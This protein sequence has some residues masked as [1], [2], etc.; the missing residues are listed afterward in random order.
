MASAACEE[1]DIERGVVIAL[2]D[3]PI[4]NL[5][6]FRG[7]HPL[8]APDAA[9]QGAAVL[10]IARRLTEC[11]L[12]IVLI[13]GGGSAMLELPVS[14]VSMADIR[15][16]TRLLLLAGADIA[17]L[18]AV[19]G[20]LSQVKGGGLARALHPARIIIIV[21]SD[22]PGRDPSLVAA[23]P[24]SRPEGWP[25]PQ[26]VIARYGLSAKLPARVRRRIA[27][28]APHSAAPGDEPRVH[29]IIAADAHMALE[30]VRA[31]AARHGLRLEIAPNV[32][33]G[34]A[35]IEGPRFVREARAR[36][37]ERLID[38]WI[39]ASETTVVVGGNGRGGRNSEAV[40]AVAN[41]KT[42]IFGTFVAIA[43]DGVDGSNDAAA[44]WLD[45]TVR[46]RG[47]SLGLDPKDLLARNDSQAFFAS[48]GARWIVG[49]T[50][51]NVA[52]IWVWIASPPSRRI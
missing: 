32:I 7:A 27:T 36:S 21:I 47:R 26:E 9:R 1:L 40:L 50:G 45:E 52:D 28:F 44:V 14:G 19:R 33:H 34:V 38:G 42:P 15:D 10:E 13:S 16:T 31:L 12:A 39:A 29:W 49:P 5:D 18:N 25:N 8:P 2:D 30:G 17:E 46:A 41:R 11:D 43:T 20:C 22:V 3:A 6:V 24:C 48:T 37:R 4:A 35:R 23:G 51:T